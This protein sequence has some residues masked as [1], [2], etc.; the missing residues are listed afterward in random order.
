MHRAALEKFLARNAQPSATATLTPGQ[1]VVLSDG[2]SGKVVGPS[3]DLNRI[4]VRTR[5]GLRTVKPSDLTFARP[6]RTGAPPQPPLQLGFKDAREMQWRVVQPGKDLPVYLVLDETANNVLNHVSRG[7]RSGAN[8]PPYYAQQWVNRIRGLAQQ[9]RDRLAQEKLENFA[10][11]LESAIDPQKGLNIAEKT[12]DLPEHVDT[13]SEELFHS[14]TR[15]GIP[16]EELIDHRHLRP[17]LPRLR[18]EA[19]KHDDLTIVAEAMNDV[20]MGEVP[21]LTP[22]QTE[23]FARDMWQ[24]I[25][26]YSGLEVLRHIQDMYEYLDDLRSDMGVTLSEER[27]NYVQRVKS[28]LD[29]VINRSGNSEN[30]PPIDVRSRG[31]KR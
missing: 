1:R 21:E 25:A 4:V 13:V 14:L 16:V 12:A 30:F 20:A 26:K 19:P 24:A 8:T 10:Q 18:R 31:R 29:E 6:R 3:R 7:E 17:M 5:G 11:A 2:R 27:R 22:D 23:E 9:Q 15:E 28:A